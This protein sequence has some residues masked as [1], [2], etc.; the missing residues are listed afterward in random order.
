MAA[1]CAQRQRK[2]QTSPLHGAGS[3]EAQT[4]DPITQCDWLAGGTTAGVAS[5]HDP[6]G[7]Y[8]SGDLASRGGCQLLTAQ[9]RGWQSRVL[10]AWATVEENTAEWREGPIRW[11]QQEA[12]VMF[13]LARLTM[14][15]M[16]GTSI[17]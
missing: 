11:E 7:G 12:H 9:K 3:A 5:R 15:A 6:C 16:S 10:E 17:R 8:C 2:S 1:F 14:V 4:R 13:R